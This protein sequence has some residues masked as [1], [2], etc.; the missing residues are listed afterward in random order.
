[1]TA[2]AYGYLHTARVHSLDPV[3]GAVFLQGLSL[4]RTSRWGPVATC[5]FGLQPGDQVVA[6]SL[7]TSRDILMV[8]GKVGDRLPD[9]GDIPGLVAALAA[10]ADDTEIT[11]INGTLDEH[12]DV[13]DEHATT[14]GTHTTTLG[15]HATTLGAH[16]TELVALDGRLD[17]AEAT[18]L[19]HA[20]RLT[21]IEA[22][23]WI[24]DRDVY[25]D[26]LSSMPRQSVVNAIPLTNGTIYATRVFGRRAMTL[27]AIRMATAVAGVGGTATVGLYAGSAV[28]SL[29]QV[30]AGAIS[31]T[32]L[33]R[34]TYT[35]ASSYV[36]ADQTQFVIALLPLAYST[37][38]QMGGRSGIVHS[39]LLNP[40]SNLY[41]SVT[42]AGQTVLPASIDL[43]DGSWT[44]AVTSVLWTALAG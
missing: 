29:A 13:L 23:G 1:M 41:T 24:H 14:L 6:A 4:A 31:L 22:N 16:A 44:S 43:M 42:K 28:T 12:A 9:I 21:N 32:T 26:A 35:F 34:V 38:P 30:K 18:D 33:G 20:G 19:N 5:V 11:A 8:I 17:T 27:L 7:G 15:A 39:T 2:P 10:K 40:A 36:S 3:T 25:T 37:A